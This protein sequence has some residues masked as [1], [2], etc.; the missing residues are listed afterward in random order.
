L[1][2]F[3]GIEVEYGVTNSVTPWVEIAEIFEG[4]TGCN[5]F[6]AAPQSGAPA[7]RFDGN[8]LYPTEVFQNL[9]GCDPDDT[10]EAFGRVFAVDKVEGDQMTWTGN[11]TLLEFVRTEE[12]PP[13]P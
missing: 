6:S 10:E 3:D 5:D 13:G 1:T 4:N 9:A 12:R 11:E 7:Y 8:V 2:A